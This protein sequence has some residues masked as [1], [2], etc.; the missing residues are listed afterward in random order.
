MN[1]AGGALTRLKKHEEAQEYI[2]FAGKF[3]S[4]YADNEVF[5][6]KVRG[7][8]H[9]LMQQFFLAEMDWANSCQRHDIET[10]YLDKFEKSVKNANQVNSSEER[11]SIFLLEPMF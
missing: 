7:E 8:N 11:R 2:T 5:E 6:E 10:Q 1:E 3:V 4:E 9:P